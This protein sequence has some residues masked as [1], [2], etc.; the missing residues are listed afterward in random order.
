LKSIAADVMMPDSC[1]RIVIGIGNRDRG[2]DAAGCS[3][4]KLLRDTLPP[5]IELAEHDGDVSALIS[6]LDGVAAA[7]L[8]DA[9]TSG[10][11]PGTVHR[12]NVAAAPLPQATFGLSTHGLGLAAAVELARAIGGLPPQCIVY[13]IEG[14][15]FEMGAPLSPAV[16]AAAKDVAVRLRAELAVKARQE[17]RT[18]ARSQTHGQPDAPD[19]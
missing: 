17:E 3:V 2:D 11:P 5:D 14:S 6:R 12:F 16:A 4:V 9:C 10:T 13:A 15:S 19:Q 7:F 8:V 18:N 1:R